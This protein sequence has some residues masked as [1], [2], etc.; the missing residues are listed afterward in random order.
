M[1]RSGD[2]DF[3]FKVLRERETQ[4]FMSSSLSEIKTQC[5]KF[6]INSL[7][8]THL[9]SKYGK[10]ICKVLDEFANKGRS[11][12][13]K[14]IF[15][16]VMKEIQ[17]DEIDENELSQKIFDSIA[18]MNKYKKEISKETKN[19]NAF[20]Y[21]INHKYISHSGDPTKYCNK[22]KLPVNHPEEFVDLK[23][24][25]A[26]SSVPYHDSSIN[27]KFNATS[28]N[29]TFTNC[30]DIHFGG[31]C[32]KII[33]DN[34]NNNNGN[35]NN[36]N[37]NKTKQIIKNALSQFPE[38]DFLFDE[39]VKTLSGKKLSMM[40]QLALDLYDNDI[41]KIQKE[42]ARLQEKCSPPSIFNNNHH[43]PD[44][45]TSVNEQPQQLHYYDHCQLQ[46]QTTHK[47]LY[48]RQ[49]VMTN[50]ILKH[51]NHEIHNADNNN[52]Y[53]QEVQMFLKN[54]AIQY[55]SIKIDTRFDGIIMELLGNESLIIL[56]FNHRKQQFIIEALSRYNDR[57][58]ITNKSLSSVY[59]DCFIYSH[60]LYQSLDSSLDSCKF[61][62]GVNTVQKCIKSIKN[63]DQHNIFIKC[64]NWNE[65][66]KFK[67]LILQ[68]NNNNNNIQNKYITLL[69]QKFKILSSS[70]NNNNNDDVY[71]EH[72]FMLQMVYVYDRNSHSKNNN[73]NNTIYLKVAAL[74]KTDTTRYCIST[75]MRYVA[76]LN[77]ES[78]EMVLLT[79]IGQI[80]PQ[81]DS[82]IN[83]NNNDI[84]PLDLKKFFLCSF[85]NITIK[86]P[87]LI[88]YN[89]I[90]KDEPQNFHNNQ[91]IGYHLIQQHA[92][93]HQLIRID[94]KHSRNINFKSYLFEIW[95]N[96][97]FVDHKYEQKISK[98]NQISY[99]K[100]SRHWLKII[101]YIN[102][103][104]KNGPSL[105]DI[106]LTKMNNESILFFKSSYKKAE[107]QQFVQQ[108]YKQ[109]H[110]GDM[111]TYVQCPI[112][113][114]FY[115]QIHDINVVDFKVLKKWIENA[116][117][118]KIKQLSRSTMFEKLCKNINKINSQIDTFAV[119]TDAIQL[120][121]S[122][123]IY[124]F[125]YQQYT[126][127]ELNNNIIYLMRRLLKELRKNKLCYNCGE[128]GKWFCSK[129]DE[130]YQKKIWY[131]CRSCYKT[132]WNENKCPCKL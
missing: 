33:H 80:S 98:Y 85:I 62:Y 13:A 126:K 3:F 130:K 41:N 87:Q 24:E 58:T 32:I 36:N 2:L 108:T 121:E 94:S 93:Y 91:Q 21:G 106:V 113:N 34:N 116:E 86:F 55:D 38:W 15:K 6:L 78:Q 48:H 1:N 5:H 27:V 65:L 31:R 125:Y 97:Q 103:L 123:V 7:T 14:K 50:L 43:P 44:L 39:K 29:I 61:V 56:Y 82:F 18:L 129:C 95:N 66:N 25:Y 68:T 117:Q 104:Q 96:K 23:K 22:V 11:F 92:K 75:Q 60:K 71:T 124:D 131:C 70:S 101:K 12:S 115:I 102:Y 54:C 49:F 47:G 128:K 77:I 42:L 16:Q 35:G 8:E 57:I 10:F 90:H 9:S 28:Q 76:K 4:K 67:K 120:R 37:K 109:V 105:A 20:I 114:C 118:F 73:N 79:Q 81:Y 112:I 51:F 110:G 89:A 30:P 84:F 99:N 59:N 45:I 111:V 119:L 83:N 26:S 88:N 69:S 19:L 72:I 46:M 74:N 40:R 132:K 64:I 52:H 127:T 107:C 17:S 122:G 63:N 100:N 53:N